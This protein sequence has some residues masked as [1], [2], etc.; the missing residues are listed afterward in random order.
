MAT[1]PLEIPSFWPTYG[2]GNHRKATP[3]VKGS[4]PQGQVYYFTVG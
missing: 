3:T 2:V 4:V 1:A